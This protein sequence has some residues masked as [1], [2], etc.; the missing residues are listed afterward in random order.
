VPPLTI[1]PIGL[2]FAITSITLLGCEEGGIIRL[3]VEGAFEPASLDFG[4]VPVDEQKA[5]PVSLENI[6]NVAFDVMSIDVPDG[7][8][9]RGIK[10][11][12]VG[13]TLLAG[14]KT[15]FEVV[16]IPTSEGERSAQLVVHISD[17]EEVVLDL[18]GVGTRVHLPRIV[19]MPTS[20][21]F[22][23]VELGGQSTANVSLK[24]EGNAPGTIDKATLASM[25]TEFR[26]STPLPIT[27]AEGA[28]QQIEL[29]FAP[30]AQGVKSD[31]MQLE[32]VEDVPSI[33]IELNG[34]GR[35]PLGEILCEPSR[36]DFG[37]VERGQV[38]SRSVSC[39]ARGGAARLV[40]AHIEGA[41]DQFFLPSAPGT[42]DLTADQSISIQVEFRPD[43]LPDV[44]SGELVVDY[45]GGGGAGSAVVQLI[46]EV[47][48]PPPTETAITVVLSWN[49]NNTDIDLHMTRPN[50]MPNPEDAMFDT[51]VDCYYANRQPDW[52]AVGSTSDDPFLD[53]DDVD[54][55]GPETIN[56]ESTAPGAYEVFVHYFNDPQL[57]SST[58][59]VEIH[60][61]GQLAG[62]FNR[63]NFQCNEIWHVGTINWTGQ[64]GTF[65][66]VNQVHMSE[67]GWC[68]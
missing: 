55:F 22:G 44:Q 40:G 62:T 45:S 23:A 2:L 63:P 50:N 1:R 12:F 37:A 28:T 53:D 57:A 25:S 20:I 19:A 4:D 35:I 66:P 26:L 59:T 33:S 38:L 17:E 39:T 36:V 68:F 11:D 5:L 60:L 8:T 18:R 54:G 56:L 15:N 51:D 61:A 46:G 21:D 30:T 32:L 14:M 3:R 47:V 64:N 16:F 6:G 65:S 67:E 7:Y 13:S 43:G 42:N 58:P 29:L 10:S 52:G 41:I 27:I 9:L 34:E 24:N 49:T 48:P 31:R